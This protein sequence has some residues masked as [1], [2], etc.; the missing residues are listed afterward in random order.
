M[1]SARSESLTTLEKIKALLK[2]KS[3]GSSR[4]ITVASERLTKLEKFEEPFER[5]T[6]ESSPRNTVTLRGSR[7]APEA[8]LDGYLAMRLPADMES[9]NLRHNALLN[10]GADRTCEF[11]TQNAVYTAWC[12]TSNKDWSARLLSLL[13]NPGCGKSVAMAC[14]VDTLGKQKEETFS[15]CFYCH[16]TAKDYYSVVF[17]LVYLLVKPDPRHLKRLLYDMCERSYVAGHSPWN[18]EEHE[19]YLQTLLNLVKV[20]VLIAVDGL[21]LCGSTDQ[22]SL[23]RLF[24]KLLQA[25]QK[26][27]IMFS[28]LRCPKLLRQLQGTASLQFSSD[29]QRDYRI[30]QKMVDMT[31]PY[32]TGDVRGFLIPSLSCLTRGNTIWAHE[33]VR[34]IEERQITDLDQIKVF[35]DEKPLPPAIADLHSRLIS[36]CTSDHPENLELTYDALKILSSKQ[37]AQDIKSLSTMVM[38]VGQEDP[39][40]LLCLIYP[41]VTVTESKAAD[42]CHVQL[43]HESYQ[44]PSWP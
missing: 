20:P 42:T 6:K 7:E 13:G 24:K 43:T 11:L 14:V 3:K 18:R 39:G 28:S 38:G 26:L 23:L 16:D 25:N 10:V 35:L 41:F 15:C 2:R 17:G 29:Y 40:R 12:E 36:R 34:L 19:G 44:R 8:L 32:L 37:V 4:R 31:L 1:A 21:D 5:E 27:H 9:Q 30:V 33:V 22:T